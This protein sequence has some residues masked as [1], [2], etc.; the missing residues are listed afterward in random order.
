MPD[1]L[2]HLIMGESVHEYLHE[3]GREGES[4]AQFSFTTIADNHEIFLFGTQGPDV[5]YYHN[6]WPW[7]RRNS[8]SKL[9]NRLHVE[10]TGVFFTEGFKKLKATN[11][12]DEDY[13]AI[14]TYLCGCLCHF[15]LDKN[16]HPYIYR[17]TGYSFEKGEEK[18]YNSY[19][20]QKL[21]ALID[22]LLMKKFRNREACYEPIHL[23][24]KINRKFPGSLDRFYREM[25]QKLFDWELKENSL[26]K[27]FRDMTLGVRLIFDPDHH[28][29]KLFAA[30][31]K[32]RGKEIRLPRPL[33]PCS[34][35]LDEDYLNER[36]TPWSHPLDEEEEFVSS[37]LDIF[38]ESKMEA[39][40][41]IL[42]A[43]AF[44]KGELESIEE[45]FKDYS[46]LT[47]KEW[48]TE[49]AGKKA[50][51]EGILAGLESIFRY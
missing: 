41:Y 23:S 7:L 21:E 27:A 5:F 43:A 31:A 45:V 40:A 38:Q 44:L 10:K 13:G 34:P 28:K 42:K 35:E 24:L 36:K 18:G 32:M 14:F 51:G 37:F 26:R 50:E 48:G 25:I 4:L 8:L 30:L 16:A 33:Y 47:N 15:A 22:C 9:G 49:A 29:K 19:A 6:F 1:I 17:L 3:I 20:H 11:T 39:C 2:T 12:C 46:Y